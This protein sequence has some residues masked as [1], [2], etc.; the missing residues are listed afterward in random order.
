MAHHLEWNFNHLD[1][2][3]ITFI[4]SRDQPDSCLQSKRHTFRHS[5]EKIPFYLECTPDGYSPLRIPKGSCA[6]WLAIPLS[7]L[8]S[9]IKGVDVK[10]TIVCQKV[11]YKQESCVTRLGLIYSFPVGPPFISFEALTK[12]SSWRFDCY[13]DI[14]NVIYKTHPSPNILMGTATKAIHPP[15]QKPWIQWTFNGPSV[16]TFLSAKPG[17]NTDIHSDLFS[18]K[19]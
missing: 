17:A 4:Q 10:C 12:H 7:E 14:Q 19:G 13:I 11:G 8:P 3:Y 6:L 5:T 15:Q 9:N 16:T 2:D 18:I 1:Q